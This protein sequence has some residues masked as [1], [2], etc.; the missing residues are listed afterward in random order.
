MQL[1]YWLEEHRTP[2][3]DVIMRIVTELGGEIIFMAAAIV[4]FWCISKNCGYFM[5]TVGFAGTVL[6]QFLKLWFHIPRPW[7]AQPDFTIVE[8]A[9]AGA[10]GYSFPSGHTQNSFASLGVPARWIKNTALRIIFVFG[11]AMTALSRMYLGVHTPLDVGVSLLVGIVLVFAMYPL[12][13]D[14]DK[15]QGRM[16]ILFFVF[17]LA[18]VAYMLFATGY[19]F[20]ESLDPE[21]LSEGIKNSWMMLFCS[22]AL[23]I[24]WLLDRKYIHFPTKAPL[25]AQV[26]KAGTGL[27][28]VLLIRAM[29]KSP[30]RELCG[31]SS[32]SEGIR[33]FIIVLF[34]GS[35][36]PLT[37][38]WFSRLPQSM[39]RKNR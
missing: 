7:V 31:G 25:W 22:V 23:L 38:K 4:V 13:R 29:L 20:P 34:A 19:A 35:V 2:L 24:V 5:L 21:Q 10:A 3:L 12:F 39:R 18:A 8:S 37:F 27:G 17:I 1:L 16:Y 11:I 33:Y 32:I 15:H 14:M 26:V 6:N 36:W 30:L 9:R 28:I